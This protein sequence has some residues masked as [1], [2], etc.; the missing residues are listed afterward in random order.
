[1]NEEERERDKKR[2]N[3]YIAFNISNTKKIKLKFRH[4]LFVN[5]VRQF[6]TKTERKRG[7]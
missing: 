4:M 5:P 1:M 6:Q 7:C 3:F 2:A